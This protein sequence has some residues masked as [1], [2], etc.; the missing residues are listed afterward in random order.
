MNSMRATLVGFWLLEIDGARFDQ[1]VVVEIGFNADP[2]VA[3]GI[4][5]LITGL[6]L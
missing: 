3:N 1:D 4:F 6:I 2:Y 5:Q